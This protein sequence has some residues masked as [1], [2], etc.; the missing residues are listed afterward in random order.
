[1]AKEEYVT[2]GFGGD[3]NRYPFNR[4]ENLME[5]LPKYESLYQDVKNFEEVKTGKVSFFSYVTGRTLQFKFF[6]ELDVLEN[7]VRQ[8]LEKS[9]PTY[10][11]AYKSLSDNESSKKAYK[12][13]KKIL[14]EDYG[15]K[16]VNLVS[17]GE[18]SFDVIMDPEEV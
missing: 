15:K 6:G 7:I 9:M 4:L 17:C 8:L 10:L 14:A 1:M 3:A 16:L 13:T 5:E 2:L 18:P 12:L 11:F